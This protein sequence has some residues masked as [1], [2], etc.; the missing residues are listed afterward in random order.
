[1]DLI[2]LKNLQNVGGIR[3]K[4]DVKNIDQTLIWHRLIFQVKNNNFKQPYRDIFDRFPDKLDNKFLV[5]DALDNSDFG[6]TFSINNLWV[7]MLKAFKYDE[8]NL[9]VFDNLAK[10]TKALSQNNEQ[11]FVQS[12]FL[13]G[14]SCKKYLKPGE[15]F[16]M[17]EFTTEPNIK[18][19]LAKEF[20]IER[21]FD[22][23][24]VKEVSESFNR[25]IEKTMQTY[26]SD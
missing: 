16:D 10:T 21:I 23:K 11:F 12:D 18:K 7:P 13:S 1:M 22:L 24:N 3:F 8:K 5:L 14:R 9:P 19:R 6:G 2:N 4:Y 26:F 17:A 20:P 25:L 15:M